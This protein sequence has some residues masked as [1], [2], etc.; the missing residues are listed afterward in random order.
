MSVMVAEVDRP[1]RDAEWH[2]YGGYTGRGASFRVV[3][4]VNHWR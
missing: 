4:C 3:A 1:R 2:A